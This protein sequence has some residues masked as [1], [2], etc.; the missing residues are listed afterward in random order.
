M[1]LVS[2][3]LVRLPQPALLRE[4]HLVEAV[5]LNRQAGGDVVA[6]GFQPTP[7][8][9]GE[10]P[11][12]LFLLRHP[13]LEPRVHVVAERVQVRLLVNGVAHQRD[14]VG[15]DVLPGAAHLRLVERLV[16]VPQQV[17]RPG[18]RRQLDG[19]GQF[20]DLLVGEPLLVGLAV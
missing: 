19:I 20:P 15:E 2:E 7:L 10:L 9:V 8:L 13:R 16:G 3:H 11:P 18:A 6:D 4:R 1:Q 14:D 12:G 5:L 17:R